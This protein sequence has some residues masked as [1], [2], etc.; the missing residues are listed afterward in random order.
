MRYPVALPYIGLGAYSNQ[1]DAFSFT[2][3]QASLGRVKKITAGVYGER[4][5]LLAATGFYSAAVAIPSKAGNIA[6]LLNYSGYKNFNEHKLGVAYARNLGNRIDLGI[7]FDH[8]GFNVP[9]YEGANA[10]TAELGMI[11]HLT[12]RFHTGMHF[13]NPTSVKI[14]KT[15]GRLAAAYKF[16]FGY[17]AADNFFAGAEIIKEEDKPVNVL[18][19]FQYC[20]AKQFFIRGGIL[21]ES[22][23][24]FAGIGLSIKNM[25]MDVSASLHPQLGISPGLLIIFFTN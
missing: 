10:V 23:T 19:S 20:F 7:Q 6:L 2:A 17:D 21:S 14:G 5:F 9:G 8:C 15:G 3:N 16:G 22:A 4:R 13:Y 25:R 24:A 12:N 1:P 18:A 11:L